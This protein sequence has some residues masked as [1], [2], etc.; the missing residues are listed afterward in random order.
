MRILIIAPQPYYSERGTPI[1]VELLIRALLERG[2]DVEVLTY[3]EGEDRPA[4]GVPI[5]RIKPWFRIKG[6]PPG[7]SLKKIL[8]DFFLF[9]KAA[10]LIRKGGYDLVHAL[11]EAAVIAAI[12]CPRKRMP[13][14]YDMDSSMA[15]QI[16]DKYPAL[17]FVGKVFFRLEGWSARR[18]H[19][20]I[21][22]CEALVDQ[23][24]AFNPGRFYVLHD[25]SL[26]LQESAEAKEVVASLDFKCV[27][28]AVKFMYI[29]NLEQYQGIDLLLDAFAIAVGQGHENIHLVIVG[30]RQDD[31]D[32]YV[33]KSRSL[34][35]SG[36]VI[37]CGPR[38]VTELGALMDRADVLV[39]PRIEGINTP[40]KVY[41]YM[42]SGR[43]L[44]AT[45]L[46]T[47]TQ[48][49]DD[50]LACLVDAEPDAMAAGIARIATSS[51]YRE[52]IAAAAKQRARERH[53]YPAFRDRVQSI[54][55]GFADEL[56]LQ[57]S[58]A[59][60]DY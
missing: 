9:W 28:S 49:L 56:G 39:S 11:E 59:S 50:G 27:E 1:A 47:H 22:M 23:Y 17:G 58:P 19:A 35:L 40:M 26:R 42:D 13:F 45:R 33:E 12:L 20:V 55:A 29:G 37:F 21:P 43:A 53:T 7:P 41:S 30:G 16:E 60:S 38:P 31:I 32:R 52:K 18:A 57:S 10:S 46:P 5:H 36:H 14:I 51:Q 25:V 44:L 6:I 15:T 2:D 24:E 8:C 34:G 3:H 4:T 48:V 54:F